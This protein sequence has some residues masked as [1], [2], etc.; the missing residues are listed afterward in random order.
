[1]IEFKIKKDNGHVIPCLSEIP[2]GAEKVVIMVHG[3]SSSKTCPTGELLLRRMPERGIG[4]LLYDQPGHGTDEAKDD[5]LTVT[6]CM[7][8]LKA[9]EQY[10]MEKYPDC[11][12]FYF[13][14]SYG[15]YVTGLYCSLREHA[16]KKAFFRSAAVIMPQLILGPDLA[17][18]DPAMQ[19]ELDEK[20]YVMAEGMR[21]PRAFADELAEYNLFE[22]YS[23]EELT[24]EMVHGELDPVVPMKYAEKFAG[25]Y[26]IPFHVMEG[27][28]HSICTISSSPDKVADLA[29]EFFLNPEK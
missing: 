5:P 29:L 11:E 21:I 3:F 14:S 24:A 1:M 26:S 22:R 10:A 16:G 15:A 2:E 4:V 19:K 7:Y 8:S 17:I 6:N 20:G 28:G 18:T 23:P 27:E 9:V 13:S 25:I 12:I